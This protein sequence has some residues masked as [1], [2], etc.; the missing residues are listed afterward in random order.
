MQEVIMA[1]ISFSKQSS[2]LLVNEK[3]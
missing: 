1:M 2:V 3:V